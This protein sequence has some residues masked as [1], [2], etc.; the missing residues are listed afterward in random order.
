MARII[1]PYFERMEVSNSDLSI[2]EK[3]WNPLQLNYDMQA[4]LDFGNLIDALLTE[5]EKVNFFNYTWNG[6]QFTKKDFQI[7]EAMK[8]SFLR[9]PLAKIFYEK[10][11]KQK[12][13]AHDKF[14]IDYLG[15]KF[16]LAVRCKFDFYAKETLGMSADLKSTTAT[17]QKAFE[18]AVMMFSYHRQ[19][20]FYCDLAN[21]DKHMIIGVC[22]TPPF[23]V[24]KV[25]I[26]RGIPLYNAGK[27]RYQELAF[28]QYQL[29]THL[30]I[31]I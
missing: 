4:A 28:K 10:S 12:V 1:D 23:P 27:E 19:G 30:K 8:N 13:I 21:V 22:K 20:A 14:E 26:I 6:L 29:F 31:A 9:D 7:A 3:Y 5:I 18:S 24:F 25:P 2:L 16:P 17:T 15:F 11:D